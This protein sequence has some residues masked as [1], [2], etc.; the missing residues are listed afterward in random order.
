M[1]DVLRTTQAVVEV[2]RGESNGY[3]KVTQVAV[4]V[5]RQESTGYLRSTQAAVEVLREAIDGWFT[6]TTTT[7]TTS[8]APVWLQETQLLVEVLS[9]FPQ[10]AEI[11]STQVL[12]EVLS[13]FPQAAEIHVSQVL[14]EVLESRLTTTSTT[15]TSTT[16]IPITTTTGPPGSTTTT[17]PPGPTTTTGPPPTTTTTTTTTTIPP[18]GHEWGELYPYDNVRIGTWRQWRTSDGA[19]VRTNPMWDNCNG[20]AMGTSCYGQLLLYPG[21]SHV[22]DVIPLPEGFKTLYIEKNRY[23]SYCTVGSI[24]VWYRGGYTSFSQTAVSPSW[25]LY[26]GPVYADWSYFQIKLTLPLSIYYTTTTTS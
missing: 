2:L 17:A 16:E 11:R 21:E 23:E 9:E 24:E 15:S 20:G 3:L 22:S 13:E 25:Q 7:T 12:V 10:A 19:Y 14:V 26:S 8:T 1:A 6:T 4:E 5:I 18:D